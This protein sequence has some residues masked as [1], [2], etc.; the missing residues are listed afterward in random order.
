[1]AWVR[2][3]ENKLSW[4]FDLSNWMDGCVP[5]WDWKNWTGEGIQDELKNC[6]QE[7]WFGKSSAL[8][9]WSSIQREINVKQMDEHG[10][11][12]A[13]GERGQVNIWK[14]VS[15]WLIGE[16]LHCSLQLSVERGKTEMMMRVQTEEYSSSKLVW[17]LL[18]KAEAPWAL[19]V[20]SPASLGLCNTAANCTREVPLDMLF[21]QNSDLPCENASFCPSSRDIDFPSSP[22]T[23]VVGP[24]GQ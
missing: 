18:C 5:Y 17:R 14:G 20:P 10:C 13:R 8:A 11:L 4:D 1:M 16:I 22:G 2:E 21:W 3:R 19:S 12:H 9:T 15:R 23:G 24:T 7:W 6:F